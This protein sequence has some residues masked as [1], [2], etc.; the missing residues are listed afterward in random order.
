LLEKYGLKWKGY[1]AGRRGAETEM[2]RFTNGNSQITAHH[3]GHTT[4]V[5]DGHYVKPL[6][7]ETRRV[8]LAFDLALSDGNKG[9]QETISTQVA[10]K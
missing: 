2:N 4:Q 6:P 1:H 10:G 7:E 3:F 9:Q 8:A 5:A